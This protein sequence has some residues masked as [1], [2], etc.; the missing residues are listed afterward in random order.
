MVFVETGRGEAGVIGQ[1]PDAIAN[2]EPSV[3]DSML[4]AQ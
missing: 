4:L 3:H 2:W 1:D